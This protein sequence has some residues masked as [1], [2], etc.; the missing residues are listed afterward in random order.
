MSTELPS[1]SVVICCYNSAPRLPKTL[2]YLQAQETLAQLEWELIVVNNASTDDTTAVAEALWAKKPIAPLR[3]VDEPKPGLSHARSRGAAEAQHAIIALVD[4]DN[5]VPPHWLRTVAEVFRDHAEVGVVGG[6]TT[7][8]CEIDPPSW[9]QTF[10]GHYAVYAVDS[11]GGLVEQ[12]VCGAG[13]CFRKAAWEDLL[14]AGYEGVLSDRKGKSLSS[15]GDVET[16]AALRLAGWKIWYEPRLLIEHFIPA[17]RLNWDY[18]SRLNSGFGKQSV[19]L[20]AYYALLPGFSQGGSAS[21]SWVLE[22]LKAAKA[23][24][25]LA[26]QVCL[27]REQEGRAAYLVWKSQCARLKTL[28]QEKGKVTRLRQR[29]ANAPWNKLTRSD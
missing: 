8:D 22:W 21:A 11:P 2:R 6:P 3:V 5:G 28:W 23:L 1:I 17:E 13:L 25:A 19:Y 12:A 27:R 26:P 15:G 7:E 14:A 4:D 9:F 10:K 29:L 20:D 18:L 16:C 24:L